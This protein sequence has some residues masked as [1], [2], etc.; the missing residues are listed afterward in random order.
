MITMLNLVNYL[1]QYTD[2]TYLATVF[3]THD[4]TFHTHDLFC[5]WKFVPL[6]LP[7]LFLS[8]PQSCLQSNF[9]FHK[10]RWGHVY[11]IPVASSAFSLCLGQ[12]RLYMTLVF[13]NGWMIMASINTFFAC[14]LKQRTT[15]KILNQVIFLF[16]FSFSLMQFIFSFQFCFSLTLWV[17]NFF[18]SKWLPSFTYS[19]YTSRS[20]VEFILCSRK[21]C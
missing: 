14:K 20:L 4:C 9:V 18:P 13:F 8:S 19:F 3:H 5:N 21:E 11:L 1:L 12:S 15:K 16:Q 6:N 17:T 2:I 10:Y 7:Q